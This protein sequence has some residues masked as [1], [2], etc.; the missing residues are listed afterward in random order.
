MIWKLQIVLFCVFSQRDFVE[1]LC[2]KERELDDT[3]ISQSEAQRQYEEQK[4]LAGQLQ[5]KI[6]SVSSK[7]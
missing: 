7:S 4:K 3:R 5:H 1:A 6:N 2:N